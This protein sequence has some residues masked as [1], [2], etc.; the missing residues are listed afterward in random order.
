MFTRA[1]TTSFAFFS[2]YAQAQEA[3]NSRFETSAGIRWCWQCGGVS[4]GAQW[5]THPNLNAIGARFMVASNPR[6]VSDD[7][8]AENPTLGFSVLDRL[9]IWNG[10]FVSAGA[11]L[12]SSTGREGGKSYTVENNSAQFNT[13]VTG[14]FLTASADANIGWRFVERDWWFVEGVIVGSAFPLL[15]VNE[16]FEVAG[17]NP[18]ALESASAKATLRDDYLAPMVDVLHI[19]AGIRF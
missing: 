11:S 13:E 14:T 19:S 7:Y 17:K 16:R 5:I 18:S 10:F 6:N 12:W 3:E 4:L 2:C 1:L 9:Y 8:A 15:M